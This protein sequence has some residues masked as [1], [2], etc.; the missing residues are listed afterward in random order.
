MTNVSSFNDYPVLTV[1]K[2]SSSANEK[3]GDPER[4]TRK[5]AVKFLSQESALLHS[6]LKNQRERIARD[7]HDGIGS[8][9]THIISRLDIMAFN[10]QAN[11][12]QLA[13]L[14][15]FTSETFQQL[16]ET[17]WVLNQPE[18]PY[19]QLTERVRGLLTRI[20][21]ESEYPKLNVV[22]YGDSEVLLSPPVAS[23]IFR[24]VQESVNNAMKYANATSVSV[25]L[26][27]D[28]T[29]FTVL[30]NDNGKGFC[31]EEIC[32]G[33][34]LENIK[35]RAEEL[36]GKLE[37]ESSGEGTKVLVEFPL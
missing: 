33:Y 26:A 34:G 31:R 25:C 28:E 35:K 12:T 7:L 24:I 37:L 2:T 10:N 1:S 29:S 8:Q 22:A 30:I 20:S 13:D 9:L 23:S 18:I 6:Q 11:Q 4:N 17:I 21:C 16:R 14:R 5:R 3:L 27:I 32:P 19:G 15:D 36:N